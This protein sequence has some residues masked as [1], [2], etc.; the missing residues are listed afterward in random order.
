MN[1]IKLLFSLTLFHSMSFAAGGWVS[2]G[3]ELLKDSH[4]PWFI[5]NTSDV[6][7][8]V[9]IDE[10]NFGASSETI[11]RNLELAINYWKS[12]FN[13][14]ITPE[15]KHFGK[16]KIAS[17]TF[18]KVP[19]HE[20][21]VN[22]RFQ[23]GY[24]EKDQKNYLRSPKKYAAVTVRTDYDPINLKAKG[25]VYLSPSQGALAY[26][27]E[28]V[29][30]NAWSLNDGNLLYVTLIHELGHVFGLPH[31]GT[32]GVLM[33]EGFVELMLRQNKLPDARLAEISFFSLMKK[34]RVICPLEPLLIV[35]RKFFDLEET[36]KCMRFDFEH[37][38][39][40]QIFGVSY[41]KLF[42]GE[43]SDSLTQKPYQ[44]PLTMF[45]FNPVFPN[46]IWL[47]ENQVVFQPSEFIQGL[48]GVLGAALV[49][50][51]KK[52]NFVSARNGAKRNIA[53][54][55]E[56]GKE[57]VGIE[58]VDETGEIISLL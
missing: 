22:I 57:G 53:I 13:F 55:F 43:T 17:Q 14:A 25:F 6:F 31:I 56:Q 50:I 46:L 27:S 45:K 49:S 20:K 15:F 19:C 2:G 38:K 18:I 41:L 28:G 36:D 35:W 51:A 58:G 24:L 9:I 4:N 42:S 10:A 33:S 34:T 11:E 23:F 48:Q 8:C 26:N 30:R 52:G 3:G 7:Y 1:F 37:L 44:I 21:K 54:K 12:E 29:A 32:M 40:N 16:L 39:A 47:P 5:N